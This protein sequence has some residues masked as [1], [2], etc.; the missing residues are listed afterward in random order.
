M[1]Q[2]KLLPGD[3]LKDTAVRSILLNLFDEYIPLT[4]YLVPADNESIWYAL[5]PQPRGLHPIQFELYFNKK[6]DLFRYNQQCFQKAA[7]ARKPFLG[8]HH[9][10]YDLFIPA[11]RKGRLAATVVSGSFLRAIP[12]ETFLTDQWLDL[13]GRKPGLQDPEFLAYARVMLE[14]PLLNQTLLSTYTRLL[15]S[16][17]Q[18]AVG[19]AD[20][21][22]FLA[23]IEQSKKNYF[24]RGFSGRMARYVTAQRDRLTW[25]VWQGEELAPWDKEEFGLTRHANTVLAVRPSSTRG[26]LSD[27]ALMVQAARL[28]FFAREW[29][30]KIPETMAGVLEGEGCFLLTSPD[31]ERKESHARLQIE[32]L[33]RKFSEDIWKSLHLK[34][35]IGVSQVGGSVSEL[36]DSFRQALASLRL[37]HTLQKPVTFFSDLS[38]TSS[39]SL[40][41]PSHALCEALA[42]G[43]EDEVALARREFLERALWLSGERPEALRA[44]LLHVLY[45]A[46]DE[47]RRRN[48]Y[49]EYEFQTLLK[50]QEEKLDQAFSVD[51]LLEKFRELVDHTVRLF[52]S[53]AEGGRLDRLEKARRYMALNC[54]RK[55]SV[56]EVAKESGF[57]VSRFSHL[58]N[59]VFGI[60]FI[61]DLLRMRL[62]EA[63]RLL[64]TS[65]LSVTQVAQSCGFST[66]SHFTHI[67]G[68]RMGVTPQEYRQKQSSDFFTEPEKEKKN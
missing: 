47:L 49:Q 54:R 26:G 52:Q 2:N 31:P 18:L 40:Y 9:G 59:Q 66:S 5:S 6:K 21:V 37:G 53:P 1:K 39:A 29:C 38:L 17:G 3:P 33:A 8:Q 44:H 67:F 28:Q 61:D 48:V 51:Q 41:D 19:E 22:K 63:G 68:K 27:L 58:Y 34:V 12:D 46:W 50:S 25:G 23:E 35:D 43:R 4:C 7:R 62:E 32:D 65:S 57:S 13:S 30:W 16:V 36:P 20:P 24:A 14:T 15:E 55:L 10:L 64:K 45:L 42:R 11:F 56:G 60:S